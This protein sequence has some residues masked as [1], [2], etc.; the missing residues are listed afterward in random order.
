MLT[1]KYFS[2]PPT[3]KNSHQKLS[4]RCQILHITLHVVSRVDSTIYVVDRLR[5]Y[6]AADLPFVFSN[7]KSRFSYMMRP[8]YRSP[9]VQCFHDAAHMHE[10]R[11]HLCWVLLSFI[12]HSIYSHSEPS[13]DSINTG[14]SCSCSF[15]PR[16]EK[17]NILH[18]R[19]QRCRSASR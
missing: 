14:L 6:H 2:C 16:H 15:E 3:V 7:A 5:C 18:M 4:I 19:K 10:A 1:R 8:I 9:L 13:C 17:T 11:L 12:L